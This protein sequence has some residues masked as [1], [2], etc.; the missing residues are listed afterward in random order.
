MRCPRAAKIPGWLQRPYRLLTDSHRKGHWG[1]YTVLLKGFVMD[2]NRTW[3][4]FRLQGT[5]R[6]SCSA[7]ETL[8]S[9]STFPSHQNKRVKKEKT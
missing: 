9:F 1:F 4:Y 5:F 6:P 7:G 3:G 8:L 2:E